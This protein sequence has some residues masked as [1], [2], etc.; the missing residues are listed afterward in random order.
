MK[1]LLSSMK[2]RLRSMNNLLCSMKVHSD[3]YEKT[4][5]LYQKTLTLYESS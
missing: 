1:N 3:Y 5:T 4:L 2:K